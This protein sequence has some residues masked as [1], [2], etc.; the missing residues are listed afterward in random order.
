MG[1]AERGLIQAHQTRCLHISLSFVAHKA[2]KRHGEKQF[3]SATHVTMARMMFFLWSVLFGL[4]APHS[5]MMRP[6][7]DNK[8]VDNRHC[9]RGPLNT[10]NCAGPCIATNPWQYNQSAPIT[11]WKRAS[12]QRVVWTMNKHHHGF[13]RLALVPVHQRD[14]FEAHE[15]H[16]FH[17]TCF[18]TGVRKCDHEK[19]FC[20]T[21]GK[22]YQT[23]IK[24]PRVK[25]FM[26]RPR[27]DN[28]LVDKRHGRRR[29][30]ST[31]NSGG[32]ALPRRRG[33]I[34][35]ARR[36]RCGS[37]EVSSVCCGR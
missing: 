3:L 4:V 20:G 8:L 15:K 16:A 13:V 1:L 17:Y 29:T 35:T 12:K 10:D 28:K 19:Y 23:K 30:L 2:V 24:E 5:F 36:S 6:T 9:R 14:S 21:S 22:L 34:I 11:V 37:E 33:N 18:E 32:H 7:T 27:T 31:D 26:V 25:G